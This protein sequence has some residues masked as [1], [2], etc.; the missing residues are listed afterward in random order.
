MKPFVIGLTGSIGMGKS[1]C[2]NILNKFGFLVFSADAIVKKE[3]EPGGAA[4]DFVAT[5]WPKML[6]DGNIDSNSWSDFVFGHPDVLDQLEI[7][8]HPIV[9]KSESAFLQKALKEK[10]PVVILEIPLLFETGAEKRCDITLCVSAP[11]DVQRS[12]VLLRLNMNE[13]RFKNILA[14]QL[15]DDKKCE[16][17]DYV[18]PTGISLDATEE[19][20]HKLFIDL[21]LIG[22]QSQPCRNTAQ[23]PC[24]ISCFTKITS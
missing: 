12:R 21:G 6:K 11:P 24:S 15:P 4:Y 14:R 8:L 18:I 2:A 1:A 7:I 19:H 16:R 20:L 10:I 23:S 9:K 22:K 13:K 17:A 3:Y 5:K